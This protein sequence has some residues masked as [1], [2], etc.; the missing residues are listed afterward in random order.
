MT[1]E[2]KQLISFPTI[3]IGFV[4]T[5]GEWPFTTHF[6]TE[7]QLDRFVQ[8]C[9]SETYSYLH[10]DATGSL[11]RKPHKQNPVFFYSM[12]FKSTNDDSS[13][14][15]LSG[16]L[17]CDQTAA[18]IT[19]YFNCV[20]SKLAYRSK[21]ARPS[22]VVI[23][24][25]AALLN[26]TLSAFNV[27]NINNHLRRCSNILDKAYSASQLQGVTIVRLCCSHVMKA[28]A[29]SLNAIEKSKDARRQLMTLFA[30]LLNS[31]HLSGVYDLYE[32]IMHIY[33][34]P[35]DENSLTKLNFLLGTVGSSDE[36]IEK[37]L[38]ME[39]DDDQPPHFL[40]E[41]DVKRDAI[42]HQSPFNIKACARIAVLRQ[43]MNKERTDKPVTNRL[44]SEKI[45]CL[46]YKWFAYLP[47]WSCIMADFKDR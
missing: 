13:M 22:F 9:K 31:H 4:Q 33:A 26:S 46:F 36:E 45:V 20:L 37:H 16:A 30:T 29:R 39:N 15:P 28:F 38:N 40:D 41:I 2:W 6:F 25:S 7:D 47:L 21:T 42:I 12:V 35:D 19:A 3:S 43:I 24:F 10:I 17:L 44:Y 27:E 34:D 23:D 1:S 11:V 8:Y 14:L 5:S 32:Q 18:S